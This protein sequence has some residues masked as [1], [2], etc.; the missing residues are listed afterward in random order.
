MKGYENF[1]AVIKQHLDERAKTDKLFAKSYKKKN[2]SLEGC[3]NYIMSEAQKL[4]KSG[5]IAIPREEVFGWAVH[6]YDEDTIKDVKKT[7]CQ[8]IV[9][10]IEADEPK[11]MGL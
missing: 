4:A 7:Q 3:C 11:I 1:M 8:T 6:Y 5:Q 2:K 9:S 10:P